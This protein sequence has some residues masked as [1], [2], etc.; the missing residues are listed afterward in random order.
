VVAQLLDAEAACRLAVFLHGAAATSPKP[1][2]DRSRIDGDRRHRALATA[3]AADE[4]R[5]RSS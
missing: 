2:K 5:V 3:D 1:K 4:T